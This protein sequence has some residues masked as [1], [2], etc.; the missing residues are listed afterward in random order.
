MPVT[1]EL[2][3]YFRPVISTACTFEVADQLGRQ[4]ETEIVS[5]SLSRVAPKRVFID[6]VK[7][8]WRGS[9]ELA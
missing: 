1:N 3:L 6:H 9:Y 4:P 7:G 2:L 8:Q 5:Q